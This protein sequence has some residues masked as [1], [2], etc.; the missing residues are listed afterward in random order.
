MEGMEKVMGRW[1][2][3]VTGQLLSAAGR[4]AAA[5]ALGVALVSG[6]AAGSA[7]AGPVAAA[8]PA[9]V[10]VSAPAASGANLAYVPQCSSS[11]WC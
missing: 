6:T 4:S 1:L 9:V 7:V 10:P 2:Q 8:G 11:G 5:A 3:S